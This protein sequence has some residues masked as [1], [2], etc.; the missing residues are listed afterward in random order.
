MSTRRE[1][2]RS[3]LG[4]GAL[5]AAGLAGLP[6]KAFAGSLEPRRVAVHNLHTGESLNA[7]YWDD[8][9]YVPDAMQAL[10]KLLRDFRTGDVHAIDP[11]LY[12]ILDALSAKVG[13]RGPYQVIS[14][15]RSP[16]TNAMLHAR[17]EGVAAH[18]LHMDGMAM[19]IR[20]DGVALNHLHTAA[21]SLKKGGV[22]FYPVSNFVHV[23]VGRVRT[24]KGI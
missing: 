15:Y 11:G 18:S 5:G 6:V 21:L 17:S 2:L 16:K 7:V 10:N 19:D 4:A 8:G 20:L 9:A 23:D 13:N 22:G 1:L 12:D 24:W 14:G 3:V